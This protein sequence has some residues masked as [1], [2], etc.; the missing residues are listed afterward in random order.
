MNIIRDSFA[1]FSIQFLEMHC[2]RHITFDFKVSVV[3]PKRIRFFI[4]AL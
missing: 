4:L 3:Y 2:V 1:F